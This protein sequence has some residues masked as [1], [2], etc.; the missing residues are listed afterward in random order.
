M[1][2]YNVG[3]KVR[4]RSDLTPG[5]VYGATNATV[6]MCEFAGQEVTVSRGGN[7]FFLVKEYQDKYPNHA[8][9]TPEMLDPGL[10]ETTEEVLEGIKNL[11]ID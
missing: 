8:I 11:E 9:F 3:D 1:K 4:I 5:I 10:D 6:R 7:F 2:E